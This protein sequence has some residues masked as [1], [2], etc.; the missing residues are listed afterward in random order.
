MKS[1]IRIYIFLSYVFT[2]LVGFTSVIFTFNNILKPKGMSE[3]SSILGLGLLFF[4]ALIGAFITYRIFKFSFKAE[5]TFVHHLCLGFCASTLTV[6]FVSFSLFLLSSFE[7]NF[8]LNLGSLILYLFIFLVTGFIYSLPG[9]MIS[10]LMLGYINYL[11]NN[12]RPR[13]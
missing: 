7:N 3:F 1:K 6:L 5:K 9:I 13:S 10:G 12:Y 2:F 4:L 11:I 8:N